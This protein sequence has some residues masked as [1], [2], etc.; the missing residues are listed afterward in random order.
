MSSDIERLTSEKMAL[1]ETVKRLNRELAKLEAFKR[2]VLQTVNVSRST[3]W[4][5]KS[6]SRATWCHCNVR[7]CPHVFHLC[8]RAAQT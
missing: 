6:Q 8:V 1:I 7:C 4:S 2:S 5:A 3:A